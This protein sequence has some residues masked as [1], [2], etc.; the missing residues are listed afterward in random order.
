MKDIL[1][2]FKILFYN[3]IIV[4]LLLIIGISLVAITS[5][6]PLTEI[7]YGASDYAMRQGLFYGIGFILT[8]I[9]III[10]TD[11]IRAL[12]WWLYGFV[13][14]LLFGLFIHEKGIM[15]VPFAKNINGATCWY[16]LPGIGTL[17]PSEFMKIAL[18]LVVA[19]IIQKHNEFYPHLKRTVKTDFL[20][21]LKIGAAIVPPAFLIFEQPDSGVTM[22]ILFFVALM[23]FSSGI[24]WRYIFIVGSIAMVGI[25]I[26]IL[27]VGVFPDFL[28]NVL[29]IQAYKLSRFFGWFDPFGTIQGAGN[30]LA[31]GLLAIG[32]GH[33]IGNGFQSL[34]TYF[35]E[36]H[37]DFIF[38][39]IGMDFGLI[40]TLI[41]VILCGLFDFEI[42]NTATLNRG[43]YNSYLCVG[44]FGM[45][46]F[47]QIQNIGMT[48]GMLPI[49]GVTLP[50]ISYGGSSLLSYMILFGLI[51]S[52]HIEGMKLKHSEVDY[53]ERT[54]YLKTK[55][56]IK[57]N[58]KVD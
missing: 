25:T 23:I 54:L 27:A 10:G 24:K 58:A 45:L 16:I 2:K 33:L 37:T 3:P 39:V 11:R 31:K 34:T 30:Q 52:S 38:A 20:L 9:I 32:S 5:S 40:G 8:F 36:A 42:L 51:L 48:I 44:I 6:A 12:R 14:I 26:F 50:F 57:D 1:N 43:H 22:I 17:Q 47:Q 4:Y 46:F 15:N 29:G 21:L 28:T 41:T 49:T 53:H 56:Y 18:A 7:Q 35:P 13:M 19:D 55:A